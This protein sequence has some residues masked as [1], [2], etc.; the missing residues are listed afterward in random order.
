MRQIC[1]AVFVTSI[2]LS[3]PQL[4]S[5]AAPAAEKLDPSL[6]KIE[7]RLEEESKIRPSEPNSLTYL[8]ATGERPA[9]TVSPREMEAERLLTLDECLQ[10]AF[11][12][13]NEIAK[14]RET[15]LEVGGG[16]YITNSRFL[17]SIELISQYEHFRNF[18]SLNT[19]D[20]AYSIGAK[21]TQRILEFGKDNPIDV[22][23]REEQRHALFN[24]ENTVAGVFSDVRK[25]FFII[26]LK[27]Q[28]VRT[29]QE[30]LKQ[31]EKQH[32][33]KKLRMEKHNLSTKMQV[34]TA[35]LNVLEERSA[36]NTLEREKFDSK[37]DLLRLIGLPVGADK[38]EFEGQMDR[39]GLDEFDMDG[40]IRLALAQSTSV[41]LA[42]A[43]VAEQQRVVHQ[44]RY[45]Y[46]PDLRLNGGYQDEN[47]KVGAELLNEQD[48]WGLDVFGQPK[49][50]GLKEERT[51]S[52]G[53]YR[54]EVDVRGPDPGWFAGLQL[55]IPITEGGQ[56]TGKQIKAKAVLRR[57]IAA[58]EDEKDLI[59]RDVRKRYKE[60]TEQRFQ[61]DLQ[62]TRVDIESQRLAIQTQQRDIGAIDDDALERFRRDFFLHQNGLLIEQEE[63]IR[64]QEDLRLAI[65]FFK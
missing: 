60:L 44:L 26:R 11:T 9:R 22:G 8:R 52:L 48:T 14:A 47:G 54:D 16:K 28:Q 45:E 34:L 38:V 59:E 55:R 7:Q 31:F 27:E 36:I 13:S 46:T 1:R 18:D 19:T 10:L 43:E 17:P 21:I 42:E 35:S 3:S 61:R 2:V 4:R 32:E 25:A 57:L 64:F 23:F 15:I 24:Y 58:L 37:V 51:R 50:P 65:R 20:D 6:T 30:L 63:L 5:G 12:N 62:Q 39:F 40:M 53:I 49:V 29:R 56:R 33:I 41:A